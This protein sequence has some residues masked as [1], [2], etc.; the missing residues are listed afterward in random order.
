MA[1]GLDTAPTATTLE[2][3]G[4]VQQAWKGS[5]RVPHFQRDFRWGWE[6]VRR[7]FDSILKGYPIGSLLLWEREAAAAT[8]Q[9]GGLRIEAPHSD[10]AYWVVDGQ[11][12]LTSIANALH[13]EGSADSRFALAYDLER[14]EL[15]HLPAT[16]LPHVVPLPVLFDLQKI[17]R[18]FADNPGASEHLELATSITKKLRQYKV[19]AYLVQSKDTKVLQDIFDRMNN[20]GKR[21]S[22]AEVFS[23][24]NAGDSFEEGVR[25]LATIAAAVDADTAFGQIDQ[26]TVLAAVLA[27]RGPAIRRDIRKEFVQDGDEGQAAAYEAG[28]RAISRAV[29]FIQDEAGVPHYSMLAYKYLLV[30]LTRVFA[31][32]PDLDSR[33]RKLLRRW[34]WRAALAGPEQFKGGTPNAARILCGKVVAGEP[35]DSVARLLE[36][37][38]ASSRRTVDARRFSTSDANSKILLSAMW[39]LGPRNPLSGDVYTRNDLAEAIAEAGT[40]QP[41]IQRIIPTSDVPV[42][43]RPWAGNRALLPGLTV[44]PSEVLLLFSRAPLDMSSDTWAAFLRSHAAND[45]SATM[46]SL[47]FEGFLERRQADLE[48]HLV[49]FLDAMCEWGFE[50][51]PPLS[52]LDLDNF[53][54]AG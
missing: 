27:R 37:V 22:R 8:L 32:F 42:E 51:T 36:A 48:A 6:D 40:A 35:N 15:L 10:S 19:P 34:F 43:A 46:S 5:I 45:A 12:R 18:W 52:S 41:A 2:I 1:S 25:T 20:Y 31:H 7:L 11:Q 9:L 23:A 49:S 26:D 16:F 39:T 17:L 14:D 3:E 24:L 38:S 21:L 30:V 54:D 4:L 29:R 47:N 44:D 53:D 50:D 33:N 13:P 28:E